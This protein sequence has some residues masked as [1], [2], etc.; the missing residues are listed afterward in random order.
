MAKSASFLNTLEKN[1]EF[2]LIIIGVVLL[3]LIVLKCMN[4]NVLGGNKEV[5]EE[6]DDDLEDEDEDLEDEDELNVED[7]LPLGLPVGSPG[8]ENV[9]MASNGAVAAADSENIVEGYYS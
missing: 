7:D 5:D 3:L 9:E 4:K 6:E 8:E 2:I 1:K